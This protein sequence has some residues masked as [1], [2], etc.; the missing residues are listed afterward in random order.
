MSRRL[1]LVFS[2]SSSVACLSAAC[3]SVACLSV[4]SSLAASARRVLVLDV[5]FDHLQR[6]A[7]AAHHKVRRRPE[8]RAPKRAP[9]L[10]IFLR[11]DIARSGAFQTLHDSAER[12]AWREGDHQMNMVPVGLNSEK[13]DLQ[14]PRRA[15]EGFSEPR[16]HRRRK[17]LAPVFRA[18]HHMREKQRNRAVLAPVDFLH[19]MKYPIYY[20]RPDRRRA[21]F[22][23]A[24]L[25]CVDRVC[26]VTVR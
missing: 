18:E 5:A 14:H 15:L 1:L 26:Q 8:V 9:D 24:F 25:G 12:K 16:K 13:I 7:A 6:R 22:S 2:D 4:A 21:L 3:L 11:A 10:R 23:G 19:A 17:H 20:W